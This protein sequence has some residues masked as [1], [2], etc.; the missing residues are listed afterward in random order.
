MKAV[1]A[2]LASGAQLQL[3]ERKLCLRELG[4]TKNPQQTGI[5]RLRL[6]A[7]VPRA[8]DPKAAAAA[9][10]SGDG[11]EEAGAAAPTASLLDDAPGKR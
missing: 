11:L 1:A 2:G 8:A 10:A 4:R 5:G 3:H 6:N 9:A 7:D